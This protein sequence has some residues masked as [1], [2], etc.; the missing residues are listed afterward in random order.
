MKNKTKQREPAK[1]SYFF[2]EGY[3]DLLRTIQIAWRKNGRKIADSA[4]GVRDSWGDTNVYCA[5]CL[6]VF[7][8]EIGRAHV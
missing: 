7:H 4:R 1:I 5:I 8:L 6:T 3:R 2:G